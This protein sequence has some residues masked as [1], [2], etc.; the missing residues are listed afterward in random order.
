MG[1]TVPCTGTRG[2]E[3]GGGGGGGRREDF[4]FTNVY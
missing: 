4:C 3:A 1:L 2:G